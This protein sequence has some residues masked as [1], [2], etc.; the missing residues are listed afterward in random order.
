MYFAVENDS[1][2]FHAYRNLVT[3]VLE[4]EKDQ[5]LTDLLDSI[6]IYAHRVVTEK[7]KLDEVDH[8][9]YDI[10]MALTDPSKTYTIDFLK[11]INTKKISDN[12]YKTLIGILSSIISDPAY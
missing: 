5:K 10:V 2:K 9:V 4:G 6:L 3:N 12:N 7:I 8:K 11:E 1:L